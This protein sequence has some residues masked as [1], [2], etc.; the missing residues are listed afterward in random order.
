MDPKSWEA[1]DNQGKRDY[2][3]GVSFLEA[4][5]E[6]AVLVKY[7]CPL[8]VQQY[9]MLYMIFD[10]FG[11]DHS[12]DIS[13]NVD[14]ISDRASMSDPLDALFDNRAFVQ[15]GGDIVGSSA[16]EFDAM[17]KCLMVR[18]CALESRQ[19]GMMNVDDLAC[20]RLA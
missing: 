8:A 4:C 17:I 18:F 16:D 2:T 10:R 12:L 11:E 1:L 7:H 19:K 5:L 20:H 14:Q 3:Q 15:F 9:T 13:A 6:G